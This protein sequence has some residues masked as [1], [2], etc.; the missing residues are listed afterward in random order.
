[1]SGLPL[2]IGTPNG[3]FVLRSDEFQFQMSKS[4]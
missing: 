4:V 1:M 3:A 2:M